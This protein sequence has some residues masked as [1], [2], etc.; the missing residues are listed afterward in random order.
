M[1]N[2]YYILVL[3]FIFYFGIGKKTILAQPNLPSHVIN[4][5]V[6]QPLNFGSFCLSNVLGSGTVTVNYQG[7]VTATGSIYLMPSFSP[8]AQPAIFQ[9]QVCQGRNI[10]IEYSPSAILTSTNGGTLTLHPGPSEYMDDSFSSGGDCNFI[11]TIRMGGTLDIGNNSQ[12][13]EGIYSGTYE[14]VFNYQ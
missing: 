11:N 6:I 12:N 9:V 7:I 5:T 1:H 4:S 3:F 8:I 2:K 13:P 10:I 14:I